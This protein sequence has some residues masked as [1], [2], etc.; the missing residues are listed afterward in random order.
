VLSEL[1]NLYFYLALG[2]FPEYLGAVSEE[3]GERFH[4]HIKETE[5]RH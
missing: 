4:Q 1:E 5:R 3:E 2:F